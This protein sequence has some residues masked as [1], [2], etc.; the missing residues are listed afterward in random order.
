MTNKD[1]ASPSSDKRA[2]DSPKDVRGTPPRGNPDRDHDSVE[3][4]E[5]QLGKIAG[6]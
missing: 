2:E 1:K 5:E 4:G 3:K 6:N